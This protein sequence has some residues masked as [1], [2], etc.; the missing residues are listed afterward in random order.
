MARTLRL[1][2]LVALPTLLLLPRL[3]AARSLR[4]LTYNIHHG[5]GRDGVL[6]LQR[7]AS[8]INSAQ[9]DLVAL[10]ELDQGTTRTQQHLELDELAEMTGLSGFFGKTINYQ[11]GAYGNGVLVNPAFE[12]LTLE[13]HTL[14]NPAN[15]E[16]RKVMELHMR[17]DDDGTSRRFDFFAAHLDNSSGTNRQ[18]Q[19]EFIN[20]LV[21]DSNT[22]AILGGDFNFDDQGAAYAT[23]VTQWNDITAANPGRS[24]QIDYVVNRAA[25]Q[26]RIVQQGRFIVNTTT[27]VAS[28]H[29]PLLAVLELSPYSA[30]F[31]RDGRVDGWDLLGWQRNVGRVGASV[32]GDANH[33]HAVNAADLAVWKQQVG[34]AGLAK[35]VSTVPEPVAAMVIAPVL[36]V[37]GMLRRR[38]N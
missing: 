19:V 32:V 7:I 29:Y 26:W 20:N 6:D 28:D 18:A 21:V 35:A 15:G 23:L 10:Q 24:G 37:C 5:E 34:Q 2:A 13:N 4:I 14:P 27:A 12:V 31:N 33:D 22:P 11:G 16:Q 8:V 36:M 17:I 38:T 3:A 1:L 9:P 30:D 25:D